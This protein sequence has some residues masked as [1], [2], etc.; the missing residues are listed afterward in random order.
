VNMNINKKNILKPNQQKIYRRWSILGWVVFL[1][2]VMTCIRA[3]NMVGFENGFLPFW[4][5]PRMQHKIGEFILVAPFFFIF[6]ASFTKDKRTVNQMIN[7]SALPM[8]IGGSMN[9]Y[10]WF[11]LKDHVFWHPFCLVIFVWGLLAVPI[12]KKY[13]LARAR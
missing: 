4:K 7:W 12:C 6:L 1:I 9:L 8:I 3:M 11:G 2:F 13:F 10:S 5:D